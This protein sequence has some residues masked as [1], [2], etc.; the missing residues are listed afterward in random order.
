[1]FCLKRLLLAF[2]TVYLNHMPVLCCYFYCYS[3]MF[4][5]GLYLNTKPMQSKLMN[6]MEII[7]EFAVY[8]T[9]FVIFFFSEWIEDVELRYILGFV[10]LPCITFIIVVNLACVLYDMISSL[11]TKYDRWNNRRK[12]LKKYRD[13]KIKA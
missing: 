12:L 6:F 8:L 5:I 2:L 3:P 9:C 1:M 13:A 7:N 10:Y 11:K 4:S